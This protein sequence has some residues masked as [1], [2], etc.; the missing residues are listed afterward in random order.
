[1]RISHVRQ[2]PRLPVLGTGSQGV[3]LGIVFEGFSFRVEGQLSTD[4]GSDVAGVAEDGC[5][6]TDGFQIARG[7]VSRLDTVEEVL[8]V[9]PFKAVAL[10]F[11][12]QFVSSC[13]GAP[14]CVS[15]DDVTFVAVQSRSF[16]IL[17]E[18]VRRPDAHFVGQQFAMLA[19]V[20]FVVDLQRVGKLLS[21][22]EVPLAAGRLN[23]SREA[24]QWIA[25][26]FARC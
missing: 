19:G 26:N 14:A 23:L 18:L 17:V 5:R 6:V 16:G 15:N 3:G 8:N 25:L 4:S 9:R 2:H 21:I 13:V 10:R 12:D 22:V 11:F 1:M 24:G 7:F 20:E